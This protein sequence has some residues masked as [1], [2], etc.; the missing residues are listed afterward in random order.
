LVKM[1]PAVDTVI[2]V[3]WRRWRTALYA[4]STLREIAAN[5]RMIRGRHY[6][7]VIDSQ[8]LVRSGAIARIA[9]GKR[10]G[11]DSDS[12]REP[13][14]SI[15]YDVRHHVG[16]DLHAIERNRILTGMALGYASQ[17]PADFGLKRERPH[18]AS[19]EYAIL[20]HATAR[21]E[22][23][24]PEENWIALARALALP[25]VLPWGSDAERSRSERIAA[26]LPRAR[27]PPRMP[28]DEIAS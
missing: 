8:G 21:T 28:L 4:P 16:R 26:A 24:W 27:V 2:P 9:H 23:E 7:V 14:A 5:L 1:H 13:M 3:A 22:K 15:F 17:G 12:I 6:D 11:Y 25:V 20:L 19:E 10:H 18:R